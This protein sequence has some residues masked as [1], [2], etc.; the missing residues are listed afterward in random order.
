MKVNLLQY[1]DDTIFV[2]EFNVDNVVV[3]KSIMRCFELVSDLKMNI[4]NSR[5]GSI[6]VGREDVKK[7][8]KYLNC[9]ILTIPFVCLCLCVCVCVCIISYFKFIVDTMVDFLDCRAI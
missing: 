8:S 3:L 7:F 2:G 4:H 9:R 1:A 6:G 5:F